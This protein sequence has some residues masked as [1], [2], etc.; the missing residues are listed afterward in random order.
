MRIVSYNVKGLNLPVKRH[1]LYRELCT[2]DADIVCLQETHFRRMDH[3]KLYTPRYHTQFHSTYRA[4][5]R[6]VTVLIHNRISMQTHRIITDTRGRYIILICTINGRVYTIVAAYAPN[7]SQTQF[8]THLLNKLTD[9]VSGDLIICGDLNLC[10]DPKMDRSASTNTQAGSQ[11][12]QIH[13]LLRLHHLHDMWRLLHPTER[14]YT[15][16]SGVHNSYSRIDYFLLPSHLL[17]R[18][19]TCDILPFTRSDHAP[20][21]LDIRDEFHSHVRPPWRFNEH[22]LKHE[23]ASIAIQDALTNYFKENTTEEVDPFVVWQAHKAVIRGVCIQWG[24]RLK[25]QH[26]AHR[27]E[28]LRNIQDIDTQN[29]ISPTT[30]LADALDDALR[31][32]TDLEADRFNSTM[33][34]M[35]SRFYAFQNKPGRLLA[36]RLKPPPTVQGIPHLKTNRGLIHNPLDIANEFAD[37]YEKLYN[38]S[39]DDKVTQPTPNAISSYLHKLHLPKL[40]LSQM[41]KLA[42][43]ISLDE[44]SEVIKGLQKRKAPGPDGLN[45]LYYSTFTSHLMPHLHSIFNVAR[46]QGTF[47]TDML[48]AHIITLPKPGKTPDEC[49]NLRPISLLNVDIKIYGKILANRLQYILPTLIGQDQVGFI[50]G[51]QGPDSTKKLINLLESLKRVGEP[52]LI[53]SLDAEKAFDRVNWLFLQETLKIYGF[54]PPMLSAVK[55][56]YDSPS[57]TVLTAGFRSDEFVITNGTRQGCPLSPLLYALVLEPLA[58]AIRQNDDVRGI[59]I[60]PTTYKQQLYADDILLTLTDPE[61]SLLALYRELEAYSDVSFH[62]INLLKTQALPINMSQPLLDTLKMQYKFDWRSTYLV[63]L[64][65]RI[66]EKPEDLFQYNYERVLSEIR[67]LIH[68]W[69]MKEVSWLGRMAAAKMIILPKLLYVF[70]ALPLNLPKHYLVKVQSVLT[71]YVWNNKRPR[72]PRKLLTYRHRDGGLNMIHVQHYYWASCLASLSESFHTHPAPQWL[73][74]EAAYM[75]GHDLPTLLWVP[76]RARPRISSPLTSTVLHLR[77]WDKGFD[78]FT[79]HHPLSMATPMAAF[80]YLLPQGDHTRWVQYGVLNIHHFFDTAS[81]LPFETICTKF[82]VPPAMFLSYMQIHSY[83]KAQKIFSTL[84]AKIPLLSEIELF[85][86]DSQS[87]T[88]A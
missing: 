15:F 43:P 73:T 62:L 6:G 25:K 44:I 17:S 60:G 32:L 2:Y 16:R 4:K 42:S 12:S 23:P 78:S 5:S 61:V 1:S 19:T 21:L 56:L 46:E 66:T 65:L 8:L 64:G 24:A 18:V 57:A 54:P 50:S 87:N 70:R 75:E 88:K 14:D 20:L 40:S 80:K 9:V 41:T 45:G 69:R 59:Q 82:K 36:R 83:L 26:T 27:L 84:S 76:V 63:Y 7:N 81:I 85:C 35:K 11:F 29:K 58:Q 34:R 33:H 67:L 52:C 37:F 79:M 49:R 51:R 28:I 77:I 30:E 47:P 22:I 86:L 3:P 53:L 74:I 48:R 38:L 13:S 10:I 39:T 71:S 55:A 31:S 68:R 72:V